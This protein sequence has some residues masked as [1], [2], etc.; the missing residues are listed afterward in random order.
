MRIHR[1]ILAFVAVTTALAAQNVTSPADRG[2]LEG[3]SYTHYP[4]GRKSARVQTLHDDVPGGTVIGAHGYRRDAI[5]VRGIVP[6]LSCDLQVTL[7]MSPNTA[8]GAS[9]TFANNVG[10]NPVVVLPRTVVTF[11]STDR[12]SLD[13]SPTF[14]LVIPYAVP[15]VV[16]P[17]GGTLCVDVEVFGNQTPNGPDQNFSLY[18][19]AHQQYADGRA[20]QPGFRTMQGCPAPGSTADCYAN[21]DL[22]RLPNGTSEIDVSIRNGVADAGNG[23]TRAFLTLGTS[24]D[25]T[26]WPLRADCPFW[27]SAELWFALPGTMTTAGRYD[28][29][30][31][32]L[33]LLPPGFRLWCQAGSIDLGTIGMSFSDAVTLVT[34]PYGQLPM[35]VARIANGSDVAAATG[36]VS[37]SVPV[38]AFF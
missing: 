7:S 27:S 17:Q 11:P 14:E 23:L 2:G 25:G 34:P 19:D 38:M 22:W 35:P 4:L 3:S 9:G 6:G 13:P 26:P 29:T 21:L 8:D 31:A 18:L 37:S 5:G 20:L 16:P 33:P 30:L 10:A 24:I 12:P 32:N 1:S 36:S 15:F 28:D